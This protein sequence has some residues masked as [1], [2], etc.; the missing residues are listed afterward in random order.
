MA[1]IL[2]LA[3]LLFLLQTD[4]RMLEQLLFCYSGPHWTRQF[5]FTVRLFVK[6]LED[7]Q[8][9]KLLEPHQSNMTNKLKELPC[10]NQVLVLS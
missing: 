9:Q 5:P 6:K 1:I 2:F 10:M 8:Q 7:N 3:N 4:R